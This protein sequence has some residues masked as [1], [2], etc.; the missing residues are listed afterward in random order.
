MRDSVYIPSTSCTTSN[1]NIATMMMMMIEFGFPLIEI[2]GKERPQCV[3]YT[4]VLS[5]EC[6]LASKLFGI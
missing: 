5:M 1:E 3:L 6:M 4:T 2:D